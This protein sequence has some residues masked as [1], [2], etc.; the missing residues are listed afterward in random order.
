MNDIIT[1]TSKDSEDLNK[2]LYLHRELA[3]NLTAS[4]FTCRHLFNHVSMMIDFSMR[5]NQMTMFC[6]E[7]SS[8]L[9]AHKHLPTCEFT[10]EMNDGKIKYIKLPKDTDS[11]KWLTTMNKKRSVAEELMYICLH[12]SVALSHFKAF[13]E[14]KVYSDHNDY[15][16]PSNFMKRVQ[17]YLDFTYKEQRRA[18][19]LDGWDIVN[20]TEN[21]Y[22]KVIETNI[23]N[24]VEYDI[25]NIPL[26]RFCLSIYDGKETDYYFFEQKGRTIRCGVTD[27][28]NFI[29]K[30]FDVN[31]TGKTAEGISSTLHVDDN[32]QKLW[33]WLNEPCGK[34]ENGEPSEDANWEWCADA[35]FIINT[36][37]LHYGDVTMEV[38]TKVAQAPSEGKHSKQ[39]GR[40]SVRLFKTYKLVKNWK[41]QARKKAEIT[42]PCWGVRGHFRHLRNGKVIFVE[43]YVKGKDREQYKG[44]EYNL[45]PYKE[46]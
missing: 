15:R 34:R 24:G 12:A 21:Q 33:E 27:S 6:R 1:M 37:M 16:I 45:L 29:T 35:F 41:S 40:N 3:T 19:I 4:K 39:K 38:E 20:L 31:I 2:L 14:V 11:M 30:F 7:E 28:S 17:T 44:K 13:L 43:P 25:D 9:M 26:P 5:N 42:C 32:E 18:T 46:A 10:V 22:Y 23:Q 8:A 36:F